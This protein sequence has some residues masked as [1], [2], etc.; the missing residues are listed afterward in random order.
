M[1]SFLATCTECVVGLVMIALFVFA[2]TAT[3]L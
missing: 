1:M 2:I 3:V